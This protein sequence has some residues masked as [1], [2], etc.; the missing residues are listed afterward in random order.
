M[1]LQTAAEFKVKTTCF[2]EGRVKRNERVMEVQQPSCAWRKSKT[3][4]FQTVIRWLQQ[5]DYIPAEVEK[6]RNTRLGTVE[7]VYTYK[8]ES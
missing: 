6:K 3:G 5:N 1:E 2:Q 7:R 4:D 8:K